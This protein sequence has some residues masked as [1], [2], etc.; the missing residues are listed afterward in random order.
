L[1]EFWKEDTNQIFVPPKH[2]DV[3]VIDAGRPA[4]DW[5]DDIVLPFFDW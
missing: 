5:A 2:Y 3:K 1:I 4:S